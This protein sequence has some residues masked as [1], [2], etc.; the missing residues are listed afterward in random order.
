MSIFKSYDDMIIKAIGARN[1]YKAI[2]EQALK[3]GET[4]IEHIDQII[5]ELTRAIEFFEG[6]KN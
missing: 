6:G 2:K 5:E 1:L 3:D 4:D